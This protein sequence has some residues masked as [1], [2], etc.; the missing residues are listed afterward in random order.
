MLTVLITQADLC[1]VTYS[2]LVHPSKC[3]CGPPSSVFFL[4][5]CTSMSRH[6]SQGLSQWEMFMLQL[7]TM[8]SLS[9]D[10]ETVPGFNITLLLYSF[11]FVSYPYSLCTDTHGPPVSCFAQLPLEHSLGVITL[12]DSAFPRNS[13]PLM[14]K[15]I[16]LQGIQQFWAP[17]CGN[18]GSARKRLE[19]FSVIGMPGY[20]PQ[21]P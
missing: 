5:M 15:Y 3:R 4:T 8:G 12:Q 21:H 18:R 9:F 14:L 10:S 13:A 7:M 11:L 16:T 17:V 2:N 20:L 6:Y 1:I 19:K